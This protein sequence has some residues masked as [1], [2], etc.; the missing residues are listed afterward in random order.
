MCTAKKGDRH[1]MSKASDTSLNW[2]RV[3]S[4]DLLEEGRITTVQAGHHSIC[5]TKTEAARYH[6]ENFGRAHLSKPRCT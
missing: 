2:Y 1:D 3:G 5:L 4:A 6:F